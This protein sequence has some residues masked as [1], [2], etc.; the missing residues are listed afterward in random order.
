MT[1][2]KKIAIHCDL[3]KTSGLGHLSR[4]KNL[5]QELEKKGFKCFFLFHQKDRNYIVRFTKNLKTIFFSGENKIN[6]ISH[7][8]LENNFLILIIDS[9]ENNFLIKKNLVQ[10]GLFIVSIDDHSRKHY[11]N[12]VV[13]NSIDKINLNK[14]K[15]SQIWLTG[16]KYILVKKIIK[17]KRNLSYKPKKLKLL[18]HAGGSSSYKYIKDFTVASLEAINRYDL[19]ASILCTS[20]DSKDFIKKVLRKYDNIKKIKILPFIKNLS[21][22]LKNYDIVAGPSGTTT[23]ETILSGAIP[24]SV[25]IK[26]DGRDSVN[27]WNSLG[28]LTHLN[29]KE[30]KNRVILKDMWT[31]IISN[32]EKLLDLLIQNSKELDGLGPKRLAEKII[33]YYKNN[34]RRQVYKNEEK[35]NNLVVSNKCQILD[36]RNFLNARNQRLVRLMSTSSRIITWP[37]HISWW[38]S[39]D[40][41]KYKIE[42]G[43]YTVGYHWT[44]I[45]KDNNG[46]FVT[47]A[48]FLSKDNP[49]K[50]QLAY[51]V[52]KI[53]SK[54]VKKIYKKS[55]WIISMKHD[56]KFVQRLN[57]KF[58][59][60]LAS[61]RSISRI[62]KNPQKKMNMRVMEMKI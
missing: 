59:F 52:L 61:H 18:L 48:W 24:F 3:N 13:N 33:F 10:K 36:I 27:S 19:D 31:L 1:M 53:Q 54:L 62:L 50:L 42:K 11:S 30:K 60:Q 35:D 55:I 16:S 39:S 45:N 15:T 37:E 14:K 23:F 43:G 40:I 7:F 38:I 21:K 46:K 8:L 28:H 44:K 6:S 5:S 2:L 12:I 51:E 32:Y 22:K 58:G 34:K 4:M 41:K 17:R 57:S 49:E 56:N 26:N 20:K 9:Y 25:P 47:S 29:S